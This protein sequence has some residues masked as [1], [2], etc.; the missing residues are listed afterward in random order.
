M[1]EPNL[2]EMAAVIK[3]MRETTT[4]LRGASDIPAVVKN[5]DRILASVRMLELDIAEVADL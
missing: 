4:K 1:A 2:K 3:E 5:C